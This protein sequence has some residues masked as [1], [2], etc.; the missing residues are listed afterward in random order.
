MTTEAFFAFLGAA[1]GTPLSLSERAA[2]RSTLGGDASRVGTVSHTDFVTAFV[3]T[4]RAEAPEPQPVNLDEAE[5]E[6]AFEDTALRA[7]IR[8]STS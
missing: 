1:L 8:S 7:R 2:W 3:G 4:Q 6:A 5:Y